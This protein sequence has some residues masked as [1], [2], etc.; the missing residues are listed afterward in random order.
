MKL[1]SRIV[2]LEEFRKFYQVDEYGEHFRLRRKQT[3]RTA[4]PRMYNNEYNLR[5]WIP[6]MR[7]WIPILNTDIRYI[8]F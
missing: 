8:S 4:Q 3:I 2:M 1:K 5:V 7:V 6:I